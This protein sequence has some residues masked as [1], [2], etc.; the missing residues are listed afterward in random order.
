MLACRKSGMARPSPRV[1]VTADGLP[2]IGSM[3]SADADGNKPLA[4]GIRSL[5]SVNGG[6]RRGDLVVLAAAERAE[7]RALFE[8][9]A[10]Y[11]GSAG[12][13]VALINAEE[14]PT[15]V[16]ER[17]AGFPQGAAMLERS[18]IIV[19]HLASSFVEPVLEQTRCCI[20]DARVDL[21]LVHPLDL[22][23]VDRS[24]RISGETVGRITRTCKALAKDFR[25]SVVLVCGMRQSRRWPDLRDLPGEAL[26]GDADVVLLLNRR[27]PSDRVEIVLAKNR[28][29]RLDPATQD[30]YA[31]Y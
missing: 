7:A 3:L 9:V 20:A 25:A 29:G 1:S 28:H 18:S 30:L 6:L 24:G 22:I 17:L 26:E 5:D 16:T 14:H 10:L 19:P 27:R 13:R 4:T 23:A 8:R 31:A 21:V 15:S 12:H 2:T 11:I